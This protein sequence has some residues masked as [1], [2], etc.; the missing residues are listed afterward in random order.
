MSQNRQYF[1]ELEKSLITELVSKHKNVLERKGTITKA[2][3]KKT[4]TWETLTEEFNSQAGVKKRESKQIKK[5]WENIKS[6]AKK[7]IA[8]EKREA[9]M[10]GGG[11][12]STERDEGAAAIVSIIPAQMTS[13]HNQFDDDN[14]EPGKIIGTE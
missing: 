14:Y 13:L 5:C 9:K 3:S 7:S 4:V 10:T 2:L 8:K 11:T 12:A 1:S 6:R